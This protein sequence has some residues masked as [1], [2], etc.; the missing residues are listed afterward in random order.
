MEDANQ[1]DPLLEELLN[2][3]R[4]EFE[5]N[6]EGLGDLDDVPTQNPFEAEN[7]APA[8]GDGLEADQS[9]GEF[10]DEPEE[11]GGDRRAA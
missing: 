7:A 9:E 6:D 1:E 5:I 8:Q 2:K 3:E 10:P 4:L 11:K